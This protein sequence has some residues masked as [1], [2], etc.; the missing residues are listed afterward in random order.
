[1]EDQESFLIQNAGLILL[2]PFLSR[3]FDKLNLLEKGEFVDDDSHQKAILLTEYLVTGKMEFEESFL[4]LNKIICGAPLDMFVD[5]N[6]PFE[7]FD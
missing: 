4:A 1:M 6:I 2:W 5:I 7:K 3:L